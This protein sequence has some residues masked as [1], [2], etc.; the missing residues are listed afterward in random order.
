MTKKKKKKPQFRYA[1]KDIVNEFL[2]QEKKSCVQIDRWMAVP[3][4][5]VIRF[6]YKLILIV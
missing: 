5:E 2:F 4:M 3:W 6:H 1:H